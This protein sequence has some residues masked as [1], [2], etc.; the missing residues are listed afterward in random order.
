M[1]IQEESSALQPHRRAGSLTLPFMRVHL[2]LRLV[3]FCILTCL[4]STISLN[5][6]L[7]KYQRYQ[8]VREESLLRLSTNAE[9]STLSTCQTLCEWRLLKTQMQASVNY[10]SKTVVWVHLELFE[11]EV[12]ILDMCCGVWYKQ[13]KRIWEKLSPGAALKGPRIPKQAV[14]GQAERWGSPLKM[15]IIS[16]LCTSFIKN[17]QISSETW[18]WL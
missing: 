10:S 15:G 9:Q 1:S 14:G 4:E 13:F 3:L 2:K 8:K 5:L 6:I 18:L 7:T 17:I 12:R 16:D 11:F